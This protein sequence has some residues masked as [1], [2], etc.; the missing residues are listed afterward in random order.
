MHV[1]SAPE[2]S[3]RH[4]IVAEYDACM[5]S[6]ILASEYWYHGHNPS[7]AGA[8]LTIVLGKEGLARDI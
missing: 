4:G 1:S 7:L 3:G 8:M 5:G 6:L 2:V